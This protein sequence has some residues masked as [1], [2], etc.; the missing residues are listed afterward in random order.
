MGNSSSSTSEQD[1][2]KPKALEELQFSDSLPVEI[3]EAIRTAGLHIAILSVNY[4]QSPRCLAQL[5]FMVK[6]GT[7]IIPVFYHLLPSHLP[8]VG[9]GKGIYASAFTQYEENKRYPSNMLEEWKTALQTV[10][11]LP[12]YMLYGKNFDEGIL[13]KNIME[14]V[15]DIWKK[16]PLEVEKQPVTIP[17][18]HTGSITGEASLWNYVPMNL[19]GGRG[20][21]PWDDGIYSGIRKIV[22]RFG[23]VIDSITVEYDQNGQ[24]VWSGRRGGDG[25]G[26]PEKVEFD[27]PNEVL[28]SISG[29]YYNFNDLILVTSLTFHTNHKKYGPFGNYGGHDFV[30]PSVGCKIIGFYGR[31][32]LYLDAIGV[33][34]VMDYS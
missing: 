30:T 25:G 29:K 22:V 31:S 32:G 18:Y 23:T 1:E 20:G 33:H 13:L 19:I 14:K 5:S 10:S 8:W 9:K 24:S 28:V 3:H 17:Q 21:S 6:T 16:L 4:A 2:S 7:P 15:L 11:N 34:L 27:Y 26:Q 12:G